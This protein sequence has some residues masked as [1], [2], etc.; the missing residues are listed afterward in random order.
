MMIL[1]RCLL[2][3]AASLTFFVP[4]SAAAQQP[5]GAGTA[6]VLEGVVY[7][8]I[9]ERPL[10]LAVVR[11]V[12]TGRSVLTDDEGRF[13]LEL[14]A[15]EWQ[16]EI[17]ALGYE[18]ASVTWVLP[19]GV[20]N[21]KVHLHPR[22]LALDAVT[23][24]VSRNRAREII[25]HAITRKRDA[26]AGVHDY[27][28]DGY[29][30][31]VVRD[32]S[33]PPDSAE[34]VLLITET[35]STAYWE[36]PN[37]YQE[38][39]LARRQSSN[40]DAEQNFITVG[41]IVNFNRDRVD[42]QRYSL[43]SP[44]A[45]DALEHY[46]YAVLDT[47]DVGGG[48]VFRLAIRPRTETSPLFAG[49]IDVADSTYDVVAIDV[50]VNAAARF[51][52]ISDLRYRQ[53][54]R[55]VTG[56]RW[57]PHEIRLT[58]E[59]HLALPVPGIPR[60]L[61]FEHVAS[62]DGF[63]FNEGDR[64]VELG[65]V[66]IVVDEEADD[67]ENTQ[68]DAPAAVQLTVAEQAAWAR[69]DSIARTPSVRRRVGRAVGL[70][71]SMAGDPDF[72]HFN[73][74]DG[75]YV[76]AARDWRELPGTRWTTKLGY[77]FERRA[78]QYHVGGEVR[79]L[80]ARDLWVGVSYHDE[81]TRWTTFVSTTYN[82]T[83]LALAV[84]LDPLN[85]YH[86][87]GLAISAGAQLMAF[88]RLDVRYRDFEQSTLAVNTDYSLFEV[89]RSPPPNPPIVDG[90]LRSIEA[91]LSFDS[92]PLLRS[93]GVDYR[94]PGLPLTRLTLTAEIAAPE[95]IANDFSF[96][97]YAVQLERRQRTL[98]LGITTLRAVAGV[99]SGAV[100][101][102]RYFTVDFGTDVAYQGNGFN[103]LEETSYSGNRAAMLAVQHDFDRLL[104]MGSGLPLV[105]DIPFTL[106]IHGGLF[107]TDF[108][109]HTANPADS[110]LTSARAAYTE[111]GFG[112]GNL[113][114]FLSP[115]NA[116]AHFTWQLSSYPT[117]RFRFG[118][119]ITP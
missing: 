26:L 41:E 23:V 56:G 65:R 53:R 62:L 27:R 47:L 57:M 86:E 76:G 72:F 9:T 88:T 66:R 33:E 113:T 59:V 32:L 49:V 50:G 1:M 108:V 69:I 73:R 29:V 79:L 40:V 51:T 12:R 45:D 118:F 5:A 19:S 91:Q 13:A 22:A 55:A 97:R 82:P 54:M 37:H 43:V 31:F 117:H 105:R 10:R 25:E 89:D 14:A 42:L 78:W 92:R 8:S 75:P 16:L 24:T 95:L 70:A 30:K 103:T 81:T 83:F 58:G 101:P 87:R 84:R 110:L 115:L 68:W 104:F 21:R 7:D 63:Q 116:A 35:R 44:I 3:F 93:R 60:H 48:R 98:G 67:P 17:R 100:P 39:I 107:W 2:V 77:A 90:R 96:R 112:V 6:A 15:G 111:L 114:P 94:L 4:P 61:A 85:Y 99:A 20:T 46:D 18:N 109:N 34:S 64:P 38:T 102:Q 71:A 52:Y 106:S 74:V 28:Y 119:G 36:A 11:V 80:K